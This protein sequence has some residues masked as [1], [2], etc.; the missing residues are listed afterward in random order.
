MKINDILMPYS[1]FSTRDTNKE[2]SDV[3]YLGEITLNRGWGLK[4]TK[5]R[6]KIKGKMP[7]AAGWGSGGF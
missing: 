7:Q 6:G 3:L 5:G 2:R 4:K 1:T